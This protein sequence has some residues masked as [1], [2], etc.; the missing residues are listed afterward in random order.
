VSF[1]ASNAL[2]DLVSAVVNVTASGAD[3]MI[4]DTPADVG[5]EPNL[6]TDI[7]W[8]SEDIWIRQTADP[9][10]KPYPFPTSSPTWTPTPSSAPEYRDPKLGLPNY[11][12]VRVSNRGT[13]ASSGTERLRVYWT[14]AGLSTP[15]DSHWVDFVP[16]PTTLGDG[17]CTN[18]VAY[19]MEVT[20]TRNNLAKATPAAMVERQKLL[21][22]F[23]KLDDGSLQFPDNVTFWDKQEEIHK[24][25]HA[26][27]QNVHG[28]PAFNSWHRELVNRLEVLLQQV[29]PTVMLGYWDWTTDPLGNGGTLVDLMTPNFMGGTGDP[30][31]PPFANFESTEFGH[32]VIWRNVSPGAPGIFA[33][34]TFVI[35]GNGL[36]EAGQFDSYRSYEELNG[37]NPA[38]GYIGGTLGN[39]HYSF[40][41]P[42]VFLLHSN[43]DRLFA[44]WQ[45]DPARLWRLDPLRVYGSDASMQSLQDAVEPWAGEVNA[46]WAQL[47]PW[48][49]GDGQ[50]VVKHYVDPSVVSP[51]FYDT[52]PLLIPILQAGESVI[53]QIPWY[54]PNPAD[55]A[56]FGAEAGHVCVCARIE[57]SDTAPFGMTFPETDGFY[58]NVRNN[59][60]IASRN[61]H[62]FDQ[63][64]G[65]GKKASVLVDNGTQSTAA[66]KISF[67]VPSAE[68]AHPIFEYGNI[69]L[70][71][72][73]GLAAKWAAGGRVGS[74][75]SATG[76]TLIQILSPGASIGNIALVPG[77]MHSAVVNYRL[78]QPLPASV[79]TARNLDVIQ[80]TTINGNDEIVGGMRYGF[81]GNAVTAVDASNAT[82][83]VNSIGQ[84]RP[85]PFNPE[86]MIQYS[87]ATPGHV[88]IQVFDTSGRLI[89]TLVDRV[90]IAG[91]HAVRWNGR[92]T[93]GAT[94]GSGVFLYRILYPDGSTSARKMV[95]VR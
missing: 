70:R 60:N 92:S 51:P 55:F 35:H 19:G 91:A 2:S 61:L 71:L 72:S 53:L 20:K 40:H 77:E 59:N 26:G 34:N 15:W 69:S 47:R 76:D 22:A 37:H 21:S 4:R 36:A 30:A 8:A 80:Y 41:D 13:A 42:I 54:P 25:G 58:G 23:L 66:T 83:R 50:I 43:N 29:D 33:D 9:N 24:A 57:E 48:T 65:S 67:Q 17:T 5:D 6:T 95:L 52:A 14:K 38:H 90:E 11:L 94:V 89:Q 3:L 64:T 82:P 27:G 31:G 78:L 79:G 93:I 62:I 7:M 28:G 32:S 73:T 39:A 45:R 85:N 44:M 56:C 10:F 84:N 63:F 81:V 18:P 16:D 49:T 74:G 87:L 68:T 75:I 12:Y 46:T 1:S 88:K 86:T